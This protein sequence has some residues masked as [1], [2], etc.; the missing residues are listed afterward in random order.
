MNEHSHIR[1]VEEDF[2]SVE[3]IFIDEIAGSWGN[4]CLII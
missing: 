4:L 3:K 2:I 1:L